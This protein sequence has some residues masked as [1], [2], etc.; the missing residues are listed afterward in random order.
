VITT[1]AGLE[2]G[3]VKL[4]EYFTPVRE[5]NPDPANGARVIEN[6]EGEICGGTFTE[7]FA[8]SCNTVFAPL[9]ARVGEKALVDTAER[10]GYNQEPSLYNADATAAAEPGKMSIPQNLGTATDVTASAIGQ[11]QVLATPLGM[12]SVAQT[13]AAGGKRSPTPIVSDPA[14]QSDAKVVDVTSAENARVLTGLMR[15]VVTQGTGVRAALPNVEVAGKTGTAE[16][17]PKP[18]APPPGPDPVTGEPG[19]P[20]QLIDAWFLA[21]APAQKPK[22]AI[23]VMLI[24][25]PGDGGETAAPIAHDILASAL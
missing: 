25:A 13:V 1:T 23:A 17:G 22:L 16:L 5:I 15:A 24:D 21:F 18:G 14:L 7:A 9:G 19:K 3:E 10:Y 11:G 4:D 2:Q 6:N 12:A 8:K 20:E